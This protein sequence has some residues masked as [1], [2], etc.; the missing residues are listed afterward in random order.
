MHVLLESFKSVISAREVLEKLR[1]G[2]VTGRIVVDP[3]DGRYSDLADY[4]DVALLVRQD[5][6]AL[7][8][9]LTRP[10]LRKAG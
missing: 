3:L 4:R 7:A 8:Q 6:L 5:D 2:G 1:A 10:R 9:S